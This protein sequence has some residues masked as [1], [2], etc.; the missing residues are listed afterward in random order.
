MVFIQDIIHFQGDADFFLLRLI[1]I[2]I[3]VDV[4]ILFRKVDLYF[5]WLALV[6]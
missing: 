1:R 5:L 3:S 2:W 4:T 6:D